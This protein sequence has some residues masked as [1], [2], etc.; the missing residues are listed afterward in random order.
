MGWDEERG[1]VNRAFSDWIQI[2]RDQRACLSFGPRASR[3]TYERL[4][5]ELNQ[6][7]GHPEGPRSTGYPAIGSVA[8]G[9]TTTNGRFSRGLF[10]AP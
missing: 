3:E 10:G 9:R 6:K 1:V 4:W 8:S 7:R 2:D 5:Q